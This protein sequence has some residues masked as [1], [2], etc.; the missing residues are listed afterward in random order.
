MKKSKKGSKLSSFLGLVGGLLGIVAIFMGFMNFVTLTGKVLGKEKELGSLT[1]FVAAFGAKAGD[2]TPSWA[3]FSDG[4]SD[5][6]LTIALKTGILILFILLAVGALLAIFG[7]LMKNKFGKLL[8]T[9]GGLAMLAGGIMAFC[10]VAL[11]NFQS[12]GDA[13]LGYT[14][15]LGIGAILTGVIGGVGGLVSTCSGVTSLIK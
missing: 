7:S 5:G 6:K 15:S 1:G 2:E 14:Y 12:A 8:V 10:S 13:S 4:T 11:C 9:V 3:T